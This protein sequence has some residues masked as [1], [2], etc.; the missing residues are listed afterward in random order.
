MSQ[1]REAPRTELRRGAMWRPDA[2]G[3]VRCRSLVGS[4]TRL[5][6]GND[7]GRPFSSSAS[8]WPRRL[9]SVRQ[10]VF[11]V[12][13]RLFQAA[14]SMFS[15]TRQ[16]LRSRVPTACRRARF[17]CRCRAPMDRLGAM[18][19]EEY[20]CWA[21]DIACL[22]YTSPF[23]PNTCSLFFLPMCAIADDVSRCMPSTSPI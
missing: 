7:R 9:S 3:G 14:P 2:T 6:N 22:R 19:T 11:L 4:F 5:M 18:S 17:F 13:F 20:R 21:E 15:T 8:N 16:R 12:P 1:R 23:L 10:Y